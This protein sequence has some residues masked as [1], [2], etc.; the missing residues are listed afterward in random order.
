MQVK[1][2]Q[3][4][5]GACWS[6]YFPGKII[7]LWF[8]YCACYP[9]LNLHGQKDAWGEFYMFASCERILTV[10]LIMWIR[11]TFWC[12][13]YLCRSCAR[14]AFMPR[15]VQD[16]YEILQP[17]LRMMPKYNTSK[18][19]HLRASRN[20]QVAWSMCMCGL[21]QIKILDILVCLIKPITNVHII[22]R[23]PCSPLQS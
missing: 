14:V 23:C 13:H 21:I 10:S 2:Q 19:V 5:S 15:S 8:L 20:Q 12:K 1:L 7:K 11:G 3:S 18:Y 22:N 16:G 6:P 17:T 4:L 9:S